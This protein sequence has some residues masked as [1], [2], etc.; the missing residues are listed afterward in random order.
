MTEAILQR[1]CTDR[2]PELRNRLVEA[3]LY[4]AGIVARKFAG[5][6]VD[7]DDLYQVA[8][9]ALVKAIERYDPDKGVKLSSFVV[10]SM[11]GEVK[12]YFRDRSRLIRLP[13]RSTEMYKKVEA[14]RERLHEQL[15]REPTYDELAEEAGITLEELIEVMEVRGAVAP[16][17]MDNAQ[18]DELSIAETLGVSE[19]GY[20]DFEA[21]ESIKSLLGELPETERRIIE[22]RYFE[23]KSQRDVAAALDISQMTVSRAE[24]RALALMKEALSRD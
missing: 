18:D 5:R 23:G 6:G 8:S 14:A 16:A 22:M 3:H 24:R 13:R 11:I 7:Y 9:L 4:I 21:R 15:L 19:S 1:Y 10:P 20:A 2:S 12:N 17:S